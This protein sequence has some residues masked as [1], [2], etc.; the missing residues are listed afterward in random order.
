MKHRAQNCRYSVIIKIKYCKGNKAAN[1]CTAELPFMLNVS[2]RSSKHNQ[3][4][5]GTKNIVFLSQFQIKRALVLNFVIYAKKRLLTYLHV[6]SSHANLLEQ[7]K[8]EHKK[9]VQLALLVQ[10]RGRRT[11]TLLRLP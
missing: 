7:K 5:K 6:P 8:C 9:I 3:S 2:S 10:Q 4:F 1:R 11:W